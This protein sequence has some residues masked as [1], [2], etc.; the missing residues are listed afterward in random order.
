MVRTGIPP[1]GLALPGPGKAVAA[2]GMMYRL[3]HKGVNG[4]DFGR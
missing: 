4:F 2:G 1:V 3:S